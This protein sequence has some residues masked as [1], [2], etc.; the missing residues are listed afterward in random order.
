MWPMLLVLGGLDIVAGHIRPAAA[1]YLIY[2]SEVMLLIMAMWVAW[3]YPP[4]QA[5]DQL[6]YFPFADVLK[7]MSQAF[8]SI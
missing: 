2:A 4:V 3:S 5:P 1:A 7:E 8:E 6:E